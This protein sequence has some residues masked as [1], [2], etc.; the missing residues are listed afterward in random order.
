M[1]KRCVLPVKGVIHQG[2]GIGCPGAVFSLFG[3]PGSLPADVLW[4]SF[5][6]RRNSLIGMHRILAIFEALLKS[7]TK[8]II[9]M[10][11]W[12]HV[13]VCIYASVNFSRAHVHSPPPPP[14]PPPKARHRA[15]PSSYLSS[16][17]CNAD[18]TMWKLTLQDINTTT[19]SK[20]SS[21]V[22]IDS[23]F[24]LFGAR[25]YGVTTQKTLVKNIHALWF[26]PWPRTLNTHGIT[27]Y[28][29]SS[30]GQ[31]SKCQRGRNSCLWLQSRSVLSS[32]GVVLMSCRVNFH[33]VRSA[34]Q[35]SAC[36]I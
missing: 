13:S 22:A 4:G 15:Y 30:W 23:C 7:W 29:V 33:V 3:A 6:S 2:S 32:F 21:I 34:L 20:Q 16:E 5:G 26:K 8:A 14:S 36:R 12:H 24:A 31:E 10:F 28:H 19:N 35:Y 25:K 9:L 1:G 18:R 11:S 27:S 17:Y